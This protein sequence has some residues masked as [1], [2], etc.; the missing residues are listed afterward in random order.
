MSKTLS[1]AATSILFLSTAAYAQEQ[2]AAGK[3]LT[4]GKFTIA[5]GNPAYYPWVI[6]DA[7]ESGE[8]FE[9]G[10]KGRGFVVEVD[11]D[12]AA[13]G[14]GP[15]LG[16]V[17][18]EVGE[19]EEIVVRRIAVAKGAGIAEVEIRDRVVALTGHVDEDVVFIAASEEVVI[20]AAVD[21]IRAVAANDC[22]GARTALDAVIICAG[23]DAVRASAAIDRVF[24]CT[25][26]QRICA[27]AAGDGVIACAR[28]GVN[29]DS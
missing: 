29:A 11:P 1:I 12:A 17:G 10:A 20:L 2:C 3:T 18:V 22:I 14:V 5:T 26:R 9:A 23:I 21:C 8:G 13:P 6:D 7:P 28:I 4:D 27:R 15:R 16:Q 24:A 19:V 25:A